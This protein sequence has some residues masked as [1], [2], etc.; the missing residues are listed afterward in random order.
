VSETRESDEELRGRAIESYDQRIGHGKYKNTS[1]YEGTL[2]H[3]IAT[4]EGAALDAAVS[5]LG[6]TEPRRTVQREPEVGRAMP[7]IGETW[8]WQDKPTSDPMD[9]VVTL[10]GGYEI[11]ECRVGDGGF[12][13]INR[14]E[15]DRGEWTRLSEAP[16][17]EPGPCERAV[18]G[19]K[20]ATGGV[21]LVP[22]AT[23]M[24]NIHEMFAQV[25]DALFGAPPGRIRAANRSLCHD[26][27]RWDN[28]PAWAR[29][30]ETVRQARRE[31]V[32]PSW[33][34]WLAR[35]LEIANCQAVPVRLSRAALLEVSERDCEV[36]R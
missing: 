34:C 8:R 16:R 15:W 7:A 4:A 13:Y 23:A 28:A 18:M 11:A 31:V 24:A 5:E 14:D 35:S 20:P 30:Y 32:A 3:D 29:G 21:T 25:G 1:P 2:A 6:G 27:A 9:A 22:F 33:V 17:G 26:L 19:P 12:C 36:G 10:V